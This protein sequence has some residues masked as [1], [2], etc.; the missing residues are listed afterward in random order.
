MNKYLEKIASSLNSSD[1]KSIA[2]E[3]LAGAAI[4]S[5]SSQRMLGYHT[6]YH[7]TTKKNADLIRQHGF[8]PSKGGGP[9]GASAVHPSNFSRDKFTKR[10]QGKVHVTKK[11]GVAGMFAGFQ[12][13]KRQEMPG[14]VKARVSDKMWKTFKADPDMAG[15]KGSSKEIAATTKH[16]IMSKLVAGG[17][18]S[19]GPLAFM[20]KRHL[21]QYYADT[22]N[23]VRGLKG[24]GMLATGG[25]LIAHA[26]K[27]YN[28][29]RE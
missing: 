14:F 16:K 20:N 27:R 21:V 26:A 25:S 13:A 3:G 7:G 9:G 4:A 1:K 5:G 28:D 19:K 8:D 24:L 18:G 22:H 23:K 11:I 6:V 17:K 10:S 2:A 29:G 15:P 12:S